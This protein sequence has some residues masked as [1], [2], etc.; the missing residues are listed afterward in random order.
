MSIK[1]ELLTA[2]LEAKYEALLRSVDSS[3][4]YASLDYRRFLRSILTESRDCYLIAIESDRVVG[5]LPAFIKDNVAHGKVLNSLPFYGSN[6]G[7]TVAPTASEPDAVKR[8]LM[9]AFISLASSEKVIASTLISNPLQPDEAFYMKY[10]GATLRDDRIG[11]ITLLPENAGDK[12]HVEEQLMALFHQKTR[13]SIRKAQR[14][15]ITVCHSCERAALDALLEIHQQNMA[16]IKGPEKPAKVFATI[17]ESFDYDKH[18]RVYLA[19]KDGMLTAALLVFFFYRTAEYYTPATLEEYRVFQPMSLLIFE[20]MKES[21]ARG[22]R[23]WNW[24]GPGPAQPSIYNFKKRW[25]TVDQPYHYYI[26]VFDEA[27]LNRSSSELIEQY[28][29]F[30]VV[31]FGKLKNANQ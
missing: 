17:E 8:A 10:A 7:I 27:V 28:P 16:A 18:Y 11:Q 6:G 24:G 23:Y 5:L 13:N 3:L 22:M 25:G 21:V 14:S 12:Q 26:K 9:D 2:D 19:E 30:Y 20:A 4:L 31:P 1:I 29:F 15:G